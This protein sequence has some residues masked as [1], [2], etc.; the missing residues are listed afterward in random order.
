[1]E[2]EAGPSFDV[3]SGGKF[4]V[5]SSFSLREF[6]T[7]RIEEI[8]MLSEALSNPPAKGQ[9]F[10]RLPKHMRRRQMSHHQS[11]LPRKLR[12]SVETQVRCLY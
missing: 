6:G 3:M 2:P 9:L 8:Q 11:R 7:P 4:E 10:Q 12:T 5:Q 1:M